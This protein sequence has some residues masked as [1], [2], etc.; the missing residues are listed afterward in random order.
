M[1]PRARRVTSYPPLTRKPFATQTA[2][3]R[4]I[5]AMDSQSVTTPE[6]ARLTGIQVGT[7]LNK[8]TR[9]EGT[10]AIKLIGT[11]WTLTPE[12]EEYLRNLDA[13]G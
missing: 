3:I 11:E 2:A 5:A 13:A 8:L 10:G 12:G 1:T 4:L 9:L 7:A 6:F